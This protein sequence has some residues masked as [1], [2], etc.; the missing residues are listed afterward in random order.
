MDKIKKLGPITDN[1]NKA[2][3]RALENFSSNTEWTDINNWLL[4]LQTI[5]N[6]NPSPFI[7]EK[8][9][10]AKRLSQCTNPILP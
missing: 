5:L 3:D 10:F 9:L 6:D 8:I 1:L 7:N 4:S 2:L